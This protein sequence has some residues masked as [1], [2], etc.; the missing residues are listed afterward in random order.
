MKKKK[1][2]I[3]VALKNGVSVSQ[4]RKNIQE[5]LD[6]GWNNPDPK[7]QKY[8]KEIPCK[9]KKPSIDEV[10]KYFTKTAKLGYKD[11]FLT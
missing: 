11:W 4:V 9:G 10:I 1:A 2:I 7:V 3:Q 5:A 8:W 6:I